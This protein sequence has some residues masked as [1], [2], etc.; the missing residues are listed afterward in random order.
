MVAYF[1]KTRD[2]DG[3]KTR[4]IDGEHAKK[5]SRQNKYCDIR[6]VEECYLE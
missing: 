6:M 5:L 3:S 1:S 2:I 4:D